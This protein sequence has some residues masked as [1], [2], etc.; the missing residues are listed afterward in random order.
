[1]K[2]RSGALSDP[3]RCPHGAP[4]NGLESERL[5]EVRQGGARFQV[6]K[7]AADAPVRADKERHVRE[8]ALGAFVFG[9]FVQPAVDDKL[10]GV[11]P[12]AGQTMKHSGTNVHILQN[13]DRTE[14]NSAEEKKNARKKRQKEKEFM[15]K[16]CQQE[17]NNH[18]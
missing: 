9:C 11:R 16:P 18:R 3:Q 13:I 4:F 12:K 17:S 2:V 7:P 5:Q 14:S 1:L 10:V 15:N 6:R 8:R